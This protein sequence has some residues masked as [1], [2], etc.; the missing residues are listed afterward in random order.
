M[1]LYTWPLEM[2]AGSQCGQA[3]CAFTSCPQLLPGTED[4]VDQAHLCPRT[5]SLG[6]SAF[7]KFFSLAPQASE[8]LWHLWQDTIGERTSLSDVGM[9]PVASKGR[10]YENHRHLLALLGLYPESFCIA[11]LSVHH[12][13]PNT[14]PVAPVLFSQVF[15]CRT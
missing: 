5:P 14:S 6:L 11:K 13:L 1:P 10:V 15:M 8:V 2:R 4:C 9:Y 12:L 3:T 7:S